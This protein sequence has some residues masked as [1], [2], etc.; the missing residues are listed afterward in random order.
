MCSTHLRSPVVPGKTHC[1]V[2]LD[3]VKAYNKVHQNAYNSVHKVHQ[4]ARQKQR[5]TTDLD[6]RLRR[7]LRSRLNSALHRQL[8]GKTTSAINNLGCTILELIKHLE[9]SF[10]P[11]MTWDNYGQWHVD[12]IRPLAGFDLTDAEQQK[13]A[14]H[15][16]NLQPLWAAENLSKGDK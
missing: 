5:R 13:T 9:A 16:T 6:F 10:K 2:C 12:H 7:N 11:G 15:Y 14:V 3:R 8:A 4:N 1:Q